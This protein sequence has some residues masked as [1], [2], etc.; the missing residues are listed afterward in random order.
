VPQGE[1]LRVRRVGLNQ[2]CPEA[3]EDEAFASA[4]LNPPV[5]FR[6]VTPVLAGAWR[7]TEEEAIEDARRAKQAVRLRSGE[8]ALLRFTRIERQ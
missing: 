6:Y 8:V 4:W 5:R 7:E 3:E 1:G 2:T